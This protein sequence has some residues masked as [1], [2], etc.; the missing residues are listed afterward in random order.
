MYSVIAW[1]ADGYFHPDEHYQLIEF[2]GLKTGHTLEEDL[3]WEYKEQMRP[4]LQPWI[5]YFVLSTSQYFT[6]DPFI[7]IFFLRWLTAIL[8][9]IA[10]RYFIK[11][12]LF[13]IE[14]S[15]HPV[16]ILTFYFLW[17]IPLIFT[18]FSSESWST[19][20]LIFAM[21]ISISQKKLTPKNAIIL[22]SIIGIAFLLRFQTGVI[23]IS[24][25][26][27]GRGTIHSAGAVRIIQKGLYVTG[28]NACL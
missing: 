18:R 15:L 23:G 19:I 1:C 2:S 25:V 10:I 22:G 24:I 13:E 14:N 27:E 12:S 6:H 21:S 28:I 26:F 8:A 3:A 5:T 11:Q 16:Y 4:T 17:F 9:I 7:Q 20:A